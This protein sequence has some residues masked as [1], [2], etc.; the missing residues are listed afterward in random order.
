M[1]HDLSRRQILTTLGASGLL[2]ASSPSLAVASPP[3][4][5]AR[6]RL[7]RLAHLTDIHVQPE[8]GGGE[9]MAA[10]LRHVQTAYSGADKPE[11]ILFGGD[12]LMN[13]DS[14]GGAERASM[15]LDLWKSVLKNECSLPHQIAIGNHDVLRNDPVDGKKW[16]VD[17][18]GLPGRYFSFD[19]GGWRFLVLDSTSPEEGGY[20][21]R[22]AAE[23]LAWI[24]KTLDETPATTPVC[25]VSHIP[26]LG[27]CVFFDGDLIKTGNWQVPGSWMHVDAK[28]LKDIFF[29]H[30]NVKLCLSG[31]IHLADIAEYL[32]VKYACNGAVSGAWWGGSYHEFAPGYALVDLYDDGSSEVQFVNYGWEARK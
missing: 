8:K 26:I 20:K 28:I 3:T 29:Q 18:F 1:P 16:A 22:I 4:R 24:S 7:L 25:V 9:G 11:F 31:H 14:K 23:Q 32:G 13:V 12:N 27:V 2:A 10:C 17:A 5:S 21:G 19:R 30:K 15:Q 6:T